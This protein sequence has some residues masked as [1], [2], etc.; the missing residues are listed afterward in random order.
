ML[1]ACALHSPCD[2]RWFNRHNNDRRHALLKLAMTRLAQA[3]VMSSAATNDNKLF[4]LLV[5]LVKIKNQQGL[6]LKSSFSM[7]RVK[8]SMMPATLV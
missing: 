8:N 3:R 5:L 2:R 6:Y 4:L 7:Y 1:I